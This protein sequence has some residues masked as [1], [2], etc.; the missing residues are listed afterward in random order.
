VATLREQLATVGSQLTA[1]QERAAQAEQNIQASGERV[2]AR[3]QQ[4]VDAVTEH[5]VSL[6]EKVTAIEQRS[7]A[8][9]PRIEAVETGLES[10]R[11]QTAGLHDLVSEDMLNFEQT[12]KTQA[13]AIE[14]ARTAMAQ[15]DDLVERV[16]EALESL[17]STVLDHSQDRALSVS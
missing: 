10:L 15:T 12:L 13:S 16:V 3:V 9:D 4:S 2:L 7:Q 8:A 17:Q 11:K 14:S 1:A 5:V 6:E